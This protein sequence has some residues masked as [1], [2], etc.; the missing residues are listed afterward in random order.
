MR[1]TA[2]MKQELLDD[3]DAMEI[4]SNMADYRKGLL[5]ELIESNEIIP[6]L[7]KKSGMYLEQRSNP[8]TLA[9]MDNLPPGG[10]QEIEYQLKTGIDPDT[11]L[12][13]WTKRE[14]RTANAWWA[15]EFPEES[16]P[17]GLDEDYL[18]ETLEED[19]F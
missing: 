11:P 16:N 17:L 14:A 7:L 18:P 8:A 2:E 6:Y 10:E 15:R 4:L 12:S 5:L 3:P 9:Q 19:E 1:I 13:E